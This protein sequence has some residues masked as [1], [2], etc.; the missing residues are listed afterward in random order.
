MAGQLVPLVLHPRFTAL[1][2]AD[3][4]TTVGMDVSQFSSALVNVWRTPLNGTSPTWTMSFEESTDQGT[5]STCTSSPT[6]AVNEPSADTETLYTVTLNKRWFR[7]KIVLGGTQ[8][9]G[10]CWAVGFLEERLT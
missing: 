1:S 8:P 5:W 3:T 2:G 9:S 7:I 10:T 4:Y 6:P